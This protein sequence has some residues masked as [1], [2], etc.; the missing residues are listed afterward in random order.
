M[1]QPEPIPE[2]LHVVNHTILG[3]TIPCVSWT[4]DVNEHLVYYDVPE[5]YYKDD[6]YFELLDLT[7]A[8]YYRVTIYANSPCGFYSIVA[9]TEAD[10]VK[11]LIE[12]AEDNT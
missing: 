7:S 2:F 1:Q 11:L 4:I 9:S 8:I 5:I 3:V 12:H 10:M 6:E